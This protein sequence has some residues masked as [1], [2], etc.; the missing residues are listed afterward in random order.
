[1]PLPGPTS[2]ARFS[3]LSWSTEL[4]PGEVQE[5]FGCHAR[6]VPVLDVEAELDEQIDQQPH[7]VEQD[8][9]LEVDGLLF[10]D[11]GFLIQ[12]AQQFSACHQ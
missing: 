7:V 5:P 6:L 1:M 12:S 8:D 11:L 4:L 3:L 9:E 2:A 10:I